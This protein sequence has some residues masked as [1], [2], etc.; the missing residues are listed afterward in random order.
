MGEDNRLGTVVEGSD[1]TEQLIAE[2]EVADL[3]SEASEGRLD[4]RLE[5]AHYEGFMRT[6][7]GGVNEL[8]GAIVRPLHE[9][10]RVVSALADGDLTQKKAKE[11]K[12]RRKRKKE[13]KK[14]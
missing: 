13:M 12:R 5:V 2:R 14:T 1:V 8:L 4:R 6:I 11:K 9:I 10:K 3:I 7:A